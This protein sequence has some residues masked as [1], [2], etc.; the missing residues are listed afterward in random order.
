MVESSPNKDS[1][2]V[3]VALA[4]RD[5]HIADGYGIWGCFD[6]RPFVMS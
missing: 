2:R 3:A 4:P 1:A 6:A 5:I